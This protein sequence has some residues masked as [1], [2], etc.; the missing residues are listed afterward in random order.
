MPDQALPEP[1]AQINL[2]DKTK[3]YLIQVVLHKVGPAAI[4]SL[5]SLGTAFI[6]AH[7]GAFEAWGINYIPA[8][9]PAW[10]STHE[11]SGQILLLELDTASLKA[12]TG[13]IALLVALFVTGGHHVTAAITGA[14]QSGGQRAGD[15]GGNVSGENQSVP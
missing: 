8:W 1:R 2:I 15:Y 10:L 7:Q 4:G 9:S 12:I 5:L 11:I 14:P 6:L 3:I 13:A